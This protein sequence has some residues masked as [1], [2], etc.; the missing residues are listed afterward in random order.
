MG[1]FCKSWEP[2]FK[3][4]LSDNGKVLSKFQSWCSRGHWSREEVLKGLTCVERGSSMWNTLPK[5]KLHT[6]ATNRCDGE[7]EAEAKDRLALRLLAVW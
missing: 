6:E 1:L 2:F 7:S 4:L 3:K 5:E